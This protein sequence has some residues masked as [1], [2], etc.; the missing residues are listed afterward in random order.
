[1]IY[2]KILLLLVC[3]LPL[4]AGSQLAVQSFRLLENDL[5]AQ[6][7]HPRTDQN[8]QKAALIKVVTTQTGFEFDGGMLGIVAVEQ[9]TA[10]VWVYVPGRSKALTIKHPQLGL[11]RQWAYPIPIEGARTYELVLAS[12]TVETIV[13][14]AEVETQWLAI[15]TTPEGA[16]VFIEEQLVGTTPFSRKFPEGEYTYRVELPRYHP[17]AGRV[18]LR[19][20][21]E[22]LAFALRPRFGNI[23][24]TSTPEEGMT[25]YL[26]DEDTGKTTPATLEGVS[27]GSHTIRLMSRWYQPQA[28]AVTVTDNTTTT[29]PFT[30]EPAFAEVT[31]STTPA[32]S[33]LIDGSPRGTGTLTTRLL[34]GVYS[35]K[36]ELDKHH[37]AQQQLTVVA[38]KPQAVTLTLTPRVGK[39][40]VATTPFDATITLNGR[41][42]GTTPSTI[43]DLLVGSYTLTLKKQGYGTVTRTITIAEG[44]TTEVN[45][46]LPTG[47]EVTLASTPSGAQL[48]VDGVAAGTT[49]Y[50]ATLAYGSHTVRLVNGTREVSQAISVAQGG[51]ARWEFDVAELADFTEHVAGVAIELVAVRGGTF[52]MGCTGEQ[53]SECDDDERP[54]HTVTVGNF[55]LGRYEVTVAQFKAF[56]DET[57]YKTD[58]D[59]RTGGYGSYIWNGSSWE[60]KDGVNWMCDASGSKRPQSEYNHPVIHVSWN[61]AVAYCEWLSRKTGKRYRL[62]TEAEWEYAARGGTH[63][64]GYRY[65]GS[66]SPDEVAW[67]DGNSGGRTHP[68]G[69]KQPNE[70]GL[71]DM[72]GNAWEWCADWYGSYSSDSQTNPQGPAGGSCRVLRGG[73]WNDSARYCRV[74]NRSDNYPYIRDDFYGFRLALVP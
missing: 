4:R 60:K 57:G 8:G 44:Q 70:L 30:M 5:T 53:G 32:A 35:V 20:K 63:S 61:D 3:L 25:V 17:E 10:E 11:L 31:I 73:S 65:A 51:Q 37:P 15:S 16:N 12:G 68:V 47:M 58:A 41:E 9:H 21:R 49:P 50:K 1:M 22:T 56:I 43:K 13:K 52:T 24:V 27:S 28:K 45:E 29:V 67:Y 48:W 18:T 40:D 2:R 23:R 46:T 14:P 59:K 19:G 55:Y 54:A 39:L 26:D 62:P 6:V 74:S 33:I 42:Y 64:R 36:A 71:H 69:Q 72:T 34:A 7:T 66:S 38:G